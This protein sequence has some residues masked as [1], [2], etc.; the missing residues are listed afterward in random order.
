M[1]KVLK[2]T[3]QEQVKTALG[4]ICGEYAEY[5]GTCPLDRHDWEHP[6]GCENVCGSEVGIIDCWVTYALRA[7]ERV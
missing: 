1:T 3:K 5:C 2:N 7:A 4:F 6:K